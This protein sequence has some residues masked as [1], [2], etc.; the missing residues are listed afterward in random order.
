MGDGAA[1]SR[2]NESENQSRGLSEGIYY[3]KTKLIKRLTADNEL[4]RV[5]RP[6]NHPNKCWET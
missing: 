6:H 2:S 3:N 4:R 5:P 1:G